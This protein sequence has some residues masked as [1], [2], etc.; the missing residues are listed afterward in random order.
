MQ[1]DGVT[2]QLSNAPQYKLKCP[3][4]LITKAVKRFEL[5]IECVPIMMLFMSIDDY[6]FSL[7]KIINRGSL[8]DETHYMS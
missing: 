5:C 3:C 4:N 2:I 8:H 1:V 6:P 7:N